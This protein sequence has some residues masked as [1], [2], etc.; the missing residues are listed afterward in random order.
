MPWAQ[1]N[2]A[3]TITALYARRQPGRAE[4]RMADDDP[5]VVAF[6]KESEGPTAEQQEAQLEAWSDDLIDA[7]DAYIDAKIADLDTS[8]RRKTAKDAL[9]RLA[10]RGQFPRPQERD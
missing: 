6:H 1:R 2:D 8:E 9:L 10:S 4:E 7:I 5:E 3:G